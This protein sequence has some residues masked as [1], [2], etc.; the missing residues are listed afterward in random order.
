MIFERLDFKASWQTKKWVVAPF[1]GIGSCAQHFLLS[2]LLLLFCSFQSPTIPS[3]G[4]GLSSLWCSCTVVGADMESL[5]MWPSRLLRCFSW[6]RTFLPPHCLAAAAGITSRTHH[7]CS[8][9]LQDS[10]LQALRKGGLILHPPV[11]GPQVGSIW[12]QSLQSHW[13]IRKGKSQKGLRRAMPVFFLSPI[14][15]SLE[16]S[17][18]KKQQKE[19]N[20]PKKKINKRKKKPRHRKGLGA[21]CQCSSGVPFTKLWS[22]KKKNE[23]K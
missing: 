11:S 16:P 17:E 13:Q 20:P 8:L 15:K 3:W 18:K 6:F 19:T 7:T 14:H 9:L 12:E 10:T 2:C 5:T 23:T 22:Q 4:G 21:P 1:C